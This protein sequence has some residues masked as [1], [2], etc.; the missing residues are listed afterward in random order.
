VPTALRTMGIPQL[1]PMDGK[2]YKLAF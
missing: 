2:A 1:A